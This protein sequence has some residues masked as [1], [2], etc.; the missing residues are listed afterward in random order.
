MVDGRLH[1]MLYHGR[2]HVTKV[3]D[4]SM[5]EGIPRVSVKHNGAPHT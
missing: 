5:T 4:N 3:Y 1:H 2:G